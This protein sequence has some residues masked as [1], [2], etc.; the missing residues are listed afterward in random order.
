MSEPSQPSQKHKIA[1][2][3][4]G[5]WGTTIG[6]IV[7]QN[8][9][10]NSLIFDTIVPIWVYEEEID[11]DSSDIPD[12]SPVPPTLRSKLGSPPIKLSAA[13]NKIHQNIKY[14]P[15]I[16]LPENLI[17]NNNLKDTVKGASILVFSLPDRFL[18]EVLDEIVGF[19]RTY[20]RGVWC[21][22]GKGGDVSDGAVEMIMEK[23]QIYCGV[24]SGANIAGEVA[25]ERF[26]EMSIRYDAPPMDMPDYQEKEGD[27]GREVSSRKVIIN[28]DEQRQTNTKP[29]NLHL[30]PIPK[31][32]PPLD[33]SLIQKHF[34]RPYCK[35]QN[36]S[37][38]AGVSIPSAAPWKTYIGYYLRIQI[39][40]SFKRVKN[41]CF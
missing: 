41:V 38:A 28:T 10:Q 18:E 22:E 6:K 21:V 3:G 15:G 27:G 40:S 9:K 19:H 25:R 20:A 7:A 11:I 24:L 26:C 4:S 2:I 31:D 35:V 34:E 13:I 1:V 29:T 12:K 23:L 16:T 37:D 5:K 14:L 17:A 8:V 30:T 39:P 32:Y 33:T 36:I